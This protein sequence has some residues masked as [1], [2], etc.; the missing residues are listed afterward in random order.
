MAVAKYQWQLPGSACQ[1]LG[2]PLLESPCRMWEGGGEM[3]WGEEWR[4]GQV[5]ARKG[6]ALLPMPYPPSWPHVGSHGPVSV[7]LLTQMGPNRP[8]GTAQG[9]KCSLP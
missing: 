6:A 4:A 5:E 1:Q 7:K 2:R 3:G 8:S 9:K